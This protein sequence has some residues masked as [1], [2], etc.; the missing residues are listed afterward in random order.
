M[1]RAKTQR[2]ISTDEAAVEALRQLTESGAIS[3]P[4]TPEEAT[5]KAA[6]KHCEK[7]RLAV[8]EDLRD[9]LREI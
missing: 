8:V 9:Q 1:D 2:L 5:I 3:E 4:G 7:T 6:I